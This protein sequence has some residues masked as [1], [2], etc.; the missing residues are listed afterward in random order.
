MR[1]PFS[2]P[3]LPV[4]PT[5]VFRSPLAYWTLVGLLAVFTGLVVARSVRTTGSLAARYGPLR[6]VVFATHRLDPGSD[7]TQGDVVTRLVPGT[8]AP[9]GSL[10][11][12]GDAVGRVV[13]VAVFPGL[14]VMEGHLAAS[15]RKGVAALLPAGTRAVAVP[16]GG[17]PLPLVPGDT[18]DVLATFDPSGDPSGD[19]SSST[20]ADPTFPVA[21]SALVVDVADDSATVA[22]A[23]QDAA[24]VAFA[25]TTGVVTLALAAPVGEPAIGPNGGQ[26]GP[27]SENPSPAGAAPR[28]PPPP[29]R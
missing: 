7:V 1:R 28:P 26:A 20:G 9:A 17:A 29:D 2:I 18:V 23:P 21:R 10:R 24:R 22:V 5:R 25:V 8:L 16:N 14:P 13:V 12:T 19:P 4:R 6:P 15:G 27:I 11:S 3:F